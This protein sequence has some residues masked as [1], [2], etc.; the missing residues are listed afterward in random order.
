[1]LSLEV[2]IG[3]GRDIGVSLI[4]PFI[5]NFVLGGW[6]Q[7]AV[8]HVFRATYSQTDSRDMSKGSQNAN[9]SKALLK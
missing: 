9:G 7:R 4:L 6:E 2:V 1:M 5:F 8:R 3:E